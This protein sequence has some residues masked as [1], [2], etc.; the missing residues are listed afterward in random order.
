MKSEGVN[1]SSNI[2]TNPEIERL[3]AEVDHQRRKADSWD[4]WN[5]K[6]L[7]IAGLSALALAITAVGVSRSNRKL[8]DLR[9]QLDKAKDRVL[10]SDLKS[11]DLNIASLEVKALT[12]RKELLLQG[13]RANLLVGDNWQMLVSTLRKFSGQN[14]D[15][16]RSAFVFQVNGK[17]STSSPVG[18]DTEGL[19]KAFVALFKEADWTTPADPWVTSFNGQGLVIG[20]AQNAPEKTKT[21]ASALVAELS[22]VPF[23][24]SGP[25]SFDGSR[26]KRIGLDNVIPPDWIVLEVLSHE[27]PT[28]T[29]HKSK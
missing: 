23:S 28:P 1:V 7:A 17:F 20:I 12:L 8:T 10:Q 11:K 25:S 24:V 5:L 9:D 29:A 22:R 4:G 18:D 27:Q 13:P 21:A 6:L 2:P 26:F 14:I 16:R 19:A 15:V 3:T